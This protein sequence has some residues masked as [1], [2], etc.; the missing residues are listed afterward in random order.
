MVASPSGTCAEHWSNT[1]PT[2]IQ[3]GSN[4]P[5]G[6]FQMQPFA[7][8]PS[9]VLVRTNLSLTSSRAPVA[10]KNMGW[11][12]VRNIQTWGIYGPAKL[13][14]WSELYSIKMHPL[15][16]MIHVNHIGDYWG[17]MS[18]TMFD[19]Y[20]RLYSMIQDAWKVNH[21]GSTGAAGSIYP[22]ISPYKSQCKYPFILS[23]LIPQKWFTIVNPEYHL[24][25]PIL[26]IKIYIYILIYIYIY[27][28]IP[29]ESAM[30]H[31]PLKGAPAP[32]S[33]RDTGGAVWRNETQPESRKMRQWWE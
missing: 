6:R 1:D 20:K 28:Y 21:F 2:L 17:S 33:P 23:H 11:V 24:I 3:Q 26:I 25:L 18:L 30:D 4:T 27:I 31:G 12:W 14:S 10:A 7:V 5:W 32:R 15:E 8:D 13:V 19:L 9:K 16:S 29:L 22:T